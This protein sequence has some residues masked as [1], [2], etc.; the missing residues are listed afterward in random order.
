MNYSYEPLSKK[1]VEDVHQATLDVLFNCGV[2]MNHPDALELFKK[3]GCEVNGNIVK[4]PESV[5]TKALSTVPSTFVLEAVNPTYTQQFGHNRPLLGP[6]STS[7]FVIDI[8]DPYTRRN[9]TV[10]DLLNFF[11]LSET[12]DVVDIGSNLMIFP[13]ENISYDKSIKT[14]IYEYFMHMT[15]PFGMAGANFET[16]TMAKEITDILIEKENCVKFFSSLSPVS[17]LRYENDILRGLYRTIEYGGAVQ[18][19]PCSATGMTGPLKAIDNVVLTNAENLGMLILTQL[20]KP[21][22]P[23]FYSTYTAITD[24]RSLQLATGAPETFKMLNMARQ[25]GRYYDVPFEMPSAGA[26]AKYVDA[27]AGIESQLGFMN[28]FL[29]G[30]DSCTFMFGGLDTF[31]SVNLEKF[32]LDEEIARNTYA[33]FAPTPD[34]RPEAAGYITEVGQHGTYVKTKDTMKH[35]RKEYMFPAASIRGTFADYKDS[36]SSFN[37]KL[38]NI[39]NKRLTEYVKPEIPADKMAKLEDIKERYIK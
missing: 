35:Y 34:L 27:Q 29:S 17:P 23:F 36:A 39:V 6:N 3:H 33:Y 2:E 9:A 12:S 16:V 4:I 22:T 28:A 25:M 10:E 32:I 5:V 19:V 31:N 1:Q 24:M 21:G 30:T 7:P 14:S 20:I 13:V 37:S 11:K 8:N 15:K 26:D 18:C 38:T